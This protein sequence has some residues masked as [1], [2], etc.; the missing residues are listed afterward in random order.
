MAV[1]NNTTLLLIFLPARK[2]TRVY[3]AI[4]SAIVIGFFVVGHEVT[5][6]TLEQQRQQYLDAKHALKS[7]KIKKFQALA[8]KLKT[9]P[10]YP[11]LRYNYLNK[12]L[13]KVSHEEIRDFIN[14]YPDFISINSLRAKWLSQLVRQREWQI[15]LDNYVP[16]KSEKLR[17]QQLQARI[18]VNNPIYFLEDTRTLWL[19]G[20]S[21]PP[22]CDGAF[23]Q[24]YKS[25]LMTDELVWQRIELAMQN[26]NTRLANYLGRY[27]SKDQHI[28]LQRWLEMHRLPLSE[29]KRMKYPDIAITRKILMHGIKRLAKKNI[30][31]TLKYWKIFQGKYSF[32][33][34]AIDDIDFFIAVHAAKKNHPKATILL[35]QINPLLSDETVFHWRLKTALKNEDW[36]K[37]YQWTKNAPPDMEAIKYRWIYWRGRALEEIGDIEK[38]RMAYG[39]IAGERDYYGFLA[40]DRIAA[41]YQMNHYALPE[42]IESKIRV[43][44]LP[45]VQRARELLI[46]YGDYRARHEWQHALST[47]TNYQKQIAAVLAS[48]W[49]WHDRA[50]FAIA[51]AKAFDSLLLRFPLLYQ[52][53]IKKYAAKRNI[54]MSWVFALMRSESAFIENVSSSA[55][56]LG[57]MQVM[58]ATGRAVARRIGIKKFRSQDLLAAKRNIQIGTAYMQEMLAKFNGNHVLATAAYNAGPERS[59]KWSPMKGCHKADIWTEMIPFN[60]TRTYVKRVIFYARIYDWRLNRKGISMAERMPTIHPYNATSKSTLQ[61]AVACA[62]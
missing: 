31:Q 25:D 47:M 46:L 61:A 7:G 26:N 14:T 17:C 10:L 3:Y 1:R 57:L 58:P 12:R 40:A 6:A 8:E 39:L 50:I 33:P 36:Q 2:I 52:D 41:E 32:I 22:Q 42:D 28:W 62:G 15:F 19:S 49:G 24:L 59:I 30:D 29:S 54:D 56:A 27:L 60:E 11:Y 21:L 37:L 45:A 13:H 55:G 5:A 53:E 43:A 9:Y 48:E 35:D 20:K 16:Q 38:A 51:D 34:V 44:R 18:A 4:L 23:K